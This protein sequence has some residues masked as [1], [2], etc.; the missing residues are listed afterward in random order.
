MPPSTA[1]TWPVTQLASSLA[2][3]AAAWAMSAGE[4]A[5]QSDERADQPGQ[6]NERTDAAGA[7]AAGADAAGADAAGADAPDA[8]AASPALLGS[9]GEVALLRLEQ[10]LGGKRRLEQGGSA[11]LARLLA[12]FWWHQRPDD[13]PATPSRPS[14]A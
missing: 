14:C 13:R 7:D 1:S 8:S 2:R 6:P 10:R 9:L 4:G 5:G 12:A 3:K 11:R